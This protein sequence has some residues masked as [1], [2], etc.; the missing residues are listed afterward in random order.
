MKSGTGSL[1]YYLRQHPEVFMPDIKELDFFVEEKNWSLGWDW[2]QSHFKTENNNF[3]VLGEASTNYTKHPSFSGVPERIASILPNI[4][5]IY[6][7]R[8]PIERIRSMYA[9]QRHHSAEKRPFNEAMSDLNN[10]YYVEASLYYSQ[11]LQYLSYF[12][13]DKL[14]VLSTE[15]FY[16]K[17]IHILEQVFEFLDVNSEFRSEE[18]DKLLNTSRQERRQLNI[19]GRVLCKLKD[20]NIAKMLIPNSFDNVIFKLGSSPIP[21]PVVSESVKERLIAF[22]KPDTDNLRKLLGN[23]FPYWSV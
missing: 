6:L 21:K 3:K 18:F 22:I 15:E 10:N 9:H 23:D 4:K 13:I 16:R 1:W 2:Y 19:A 8:D 11:I 5:L 12:S 14:L 17:R 7:I 20:N